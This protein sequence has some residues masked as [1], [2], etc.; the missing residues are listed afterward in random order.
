MPTAQET[1]NGDATLIRGQLVPFPFKDGIRDD[2][3]NAK[4]ETADIERV[5]V[6]KGPSSMLYGNTFGVGGVINK[7]SKQP[8]AKAGY[9]LQGTFGSNGYR[10]GT[11]DA[12]GKI[13]GDAKLLYRLNLAADESDSYRDQVDSER[14]FVA[15][16]LQ[17]RFT[18]RTRL[19]V[20]SEYLTSRET[21]DPNLPLT[22][23]SRLTTL[24]GHRF[25]GEK[26]AVFS[27]KKRNLRAFLDHRLTDR[28]VIRQSFN[29]SDVYADKVRAQL[30]GA[31]NATTGNINRQVNQQINDNFFRL[32]QTDLI[33]NLTTGPFEHRVI[34]GAEF[35]YDYARNFVRVAPLAAINVHNPVYG[36]QR[37]NY[38]APTTNSLTESQSRG[39]YLQDQ[40]SVWQRRLQLVLGA[41]YDE[42]KQ[43]SVNRNTGAPSA[44]RAPNHVTPRLGLVI[45]PW[46][47]AT[48]YLTYSES[49]RP[50]TSGRPVL[51]GGQIEP[52]E[53]VLNEA[54]VKLSLLGG[55][56][57]V[58][59]AI[60]RVE[61][62]NI[63]RAAPNE[64]PGFV[65]QTGEETSDGAE[66]NLN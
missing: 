66:L 38:G 61:K 14:R 34:T 32:H 20:F 8:Q 35:S 60:Y 10:R 41:R 13:T 55:K 28:W 45:R 31:V 54:G 3:T 65:V 50:D 22:P 33:G 2:T 30:V 40:V 23:G 42:T 49:F 58:D 56:L 25:L 17:Y 51:G 62:T 24:P 6:L 4:G 29:Y 18:P 53:G 9:A 21:F 48:F 57:A 5:E 37:G 11:V 52:D 47:P 27:V 43:S 12:T 36:A 44:Y 59:A 16:V 15:P 64:F 7:V 39:Y 46:D 1:Q 63:V 19:S 26:W